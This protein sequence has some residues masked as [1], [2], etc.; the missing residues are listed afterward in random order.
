MANCIPT[1]FTCP[2][3]SIRTTNYYTFDNWENGIC[4]INVF[5]RRP[6]KSDRPTCR[7]NVVRRNLWCRVIIETNRALFLAKTVHRL[8]RGNQAGGNN[9]NMCWYIDKSIFFHFVVESLRLARVGNAAMMSSNSH[10]RRIVRL[11][12]LFNQAWVLVTHLSSIW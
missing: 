8:I 11:D 5:K 12:R 2:G 9:S 10:E 6:P 1:F 4:R 7:Q 3:H